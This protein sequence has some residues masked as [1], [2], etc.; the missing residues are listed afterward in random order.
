[1]ED[2][3]SEDF[4]EEPIDQA[5]GLEVSSSSMEVASALG[6]DFRNLVKDVEGDVG[7]LG[8]S[9]V[10]T[11]H[12]VEMGVKSKRRLEGSE[13]MMDPKVYPTTD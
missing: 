1:M 9:S 11:T 5:A 7:G 6:Y 8:F 13:L 12:H 2:V 3:W 4:S 10:R